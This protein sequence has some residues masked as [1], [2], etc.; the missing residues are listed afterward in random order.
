[1]IHIKYSTKPP[2]LQFHEFSTIQIEQ[3]MVPRERVLNATEVQ[4]A[5]IP[6]IQEQMM[7]SSADEPMIVF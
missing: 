3:I 1:M 7:D 4:M 5:A 2:K 6:F